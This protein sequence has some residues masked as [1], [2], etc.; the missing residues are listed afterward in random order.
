MKLLSITILTL[1]T[2]ALG[3]PTPG[4]NKH[5]IIERCDCVSPHGKNHLTS[6]NLAQDAV[7]NCRAECTAI[8]NTV[9]VASAIPQES[10]ILGCAPALGCDVD[11][12]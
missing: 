2:L 5:S 9:G 6:T 10:C 8:G 12:C 4:L 1:T 11:E 7:S 3:T